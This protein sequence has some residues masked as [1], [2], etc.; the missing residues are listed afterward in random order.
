MIPS[1]GE[2]TWWR[3]AADRMPHTFM[4]SSINGA[5]ARAARVEPRNMVVRS[6]KIDETIADIP[7]PHR[8]AFHLIV[9]GSGS[10]RSS[11]MK[12]GKV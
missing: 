6:L 8:N 5:L 12:I 2:S 10:R 11:Q 3:F 1:N 4:I 7:A 9:R